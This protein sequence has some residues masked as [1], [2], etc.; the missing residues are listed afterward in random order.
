MIF[1]RLVVYTVDFDMS[2]LKDAVVLL[3][4][5][6]HTQGGQWVCLPMHYILSYGGL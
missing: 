5:E 4:E 2:A 6:S 1:G 3:V